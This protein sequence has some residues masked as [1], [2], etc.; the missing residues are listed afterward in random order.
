MVKLLRKDSKFQWNEDCQRGLD[1]LKEKM[2]RTP[3]LLFPNWEKTFHVHVDA[4]TI[5]PGAILVHQGGGELDHP[6]EFAR[7]ELSESEKNYNTT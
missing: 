7:K 4:S 1:T 3:I 2:V 6:I 5:T